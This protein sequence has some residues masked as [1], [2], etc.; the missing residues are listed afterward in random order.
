MSEYLPETLGA[1]FA[2]MVTTTLAP[3]KTALIVS[4]TPPM[5]DPLAPL[6]RLKLFCHSKNRLGESKSPSTPH[7][8]TPRTG[9]SDLHISS[10]MS[11]FLD[12]TPACQ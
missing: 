10:R 3:G 5:S 4:A 9:T 11:F 8:K 2:T 6:V 7:H 1:F 12:A